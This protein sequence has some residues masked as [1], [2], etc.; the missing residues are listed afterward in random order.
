MAPWGERPLECRSRPSRADR[1]VVDRP[2]ERSL[3]C[4][5]CPERERLVLRPK[6]RIDEIRGPV[7]RIQNAQP[8]AKVTS[9]ADMPGRIPERGVHDAWRGGLRLTRSEPALGRPCT[10]FL[11][12]RDDDPLLATE[13]VP[14]TRRTFWLTRQ[15]LV[16]TQGT[17]RRRRFARQ[18][19]DGV[20][21]ELG[22]HGHEPGSAT[23]R[24][25]TRPPPLGREHDGVED[26]CGTGDTR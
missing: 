11:G 2:P 18:R 22:R 4:R 20:S 3:A 1:L 23:P 12:P 17:R 14:R 6:R 9:R 5:R 15:P 8:G 21:F 24:G 16:D 26:R 25:V 19:A 10:I 13:V 7:G